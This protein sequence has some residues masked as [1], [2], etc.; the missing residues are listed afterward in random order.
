[1]GNKH[2][3]IAKMNKL[4]ENAQG[5]ILDMD[6]V[7][8]AD[9][10]ALIDL[11]ATF[12]R[13]KELNLAVA[14]ATNNGTRTVDQYVEKLAGFGV[15]VEPWQVITSALAVAEML[16]GRFPAGTPL[17]AIGGEGV[18][19]ALSAKGFELLRVDNAE[20]AEAVVFGIDRAINFQK[21]VEATLLVRAG[22]PFY[23]TN[24]DQ[25]FPTPRGQIPGAGAWLSVITTAS[26]IEPILAGKPQTAMLQIALERLGTPK[27]QTY[28]IGDRLETD[29]AG[30][31]ALGC[32]TALVLTGVA[33]RAQG[34]AWSP[35]IDII[36]E[37][38]SALV[39][40][41]A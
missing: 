1:M 36:G 38:L 16:A 26:G 29:I 41:G 18:M 39:M 15:T 21:M 11:P 8:W 9:S 28:V 6:G 12:S 7:L 31:Q 33:T 17:F 20:R 32:P 22:K 13:F 2:W 24:P 5:L 27:A 14:L 23:A 35:K 19:Q 30:G 34:Q 3:I 10:Q 4:P 25:T 37:S 40:G